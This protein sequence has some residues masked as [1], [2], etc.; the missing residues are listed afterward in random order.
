VQLVAEDLPKA[1]A[2]PVLVRTLI[3][4]LLGNAIKYTREKPSRRIEVGSVIHDGVDVFC[5]RDNG[6]GFEPESAEKMFRAFERLDGNGE[7]DGVGLGLDIA[8]RVVRRHGGR[9]WAEG[10]LGEG[11][12]IYFTLEPSG[13]DVETPP[14][15]Q[16]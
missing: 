11:A 3:M 10:R 6:I 16:S 9:I 15:L 4:N 14:V 12:A 8:A 1:S 7:K 13:G 2:D 5:V